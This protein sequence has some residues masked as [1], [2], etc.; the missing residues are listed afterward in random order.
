GN[1]RNV[2]SGN[3]SNGVRIFGAG[4]TDN[5]VLGNYIGLDLNGVSGIANQGNGVQLDNAGP[6]TAPTAK[7][8]ISRNVIAR[9]GQSRIAIISS[10]QQGGNIVSGN[11]I[12]TNK[13]G[14]SAVPNRGH[15]V[16]IAGSMKNIIGGAASMPGMAPGNVISGNA[17]SGVEIFTPAQSALATNN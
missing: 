14:T 6:E 7:N 2:I 12:G 16:F 4:G 13:D 8:L 9:S 1:Q 3:L 10:Q 15:G 17:Q 5:M 11:N